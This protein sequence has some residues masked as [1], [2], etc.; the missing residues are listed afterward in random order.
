MGSIRED[1]VEGGPL[2]CHLTADKD[3]VTEAPSVL[4]EMREI[5]TER[6]RERKQRGV[7]KHRF[8]YFTVPARTT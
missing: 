4:V 2:E 6:G 5:E 1:N 7:H 3:G 8:T